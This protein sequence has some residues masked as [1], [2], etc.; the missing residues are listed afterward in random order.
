MAEE[1]NIF[2]AS[3]ASGMIS[4]FSGKEGTFWKFIQMADE[5]FDDVTMETE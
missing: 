3:E 4:P 5:A 2:N 1:S